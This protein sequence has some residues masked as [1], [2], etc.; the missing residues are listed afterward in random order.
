MEL[1]AIYMGLMYQNNLYSVSWSKRAGFYSNPRG[2]VTPTCMLTISP[3]HR[4]AAIRPPNELDYDFGFLPNTKDVR[5]SGISVD[6]SGGF[7]SN[8]KENYLSHNKNRKLS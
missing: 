1:M 5:K 3:S 7:Y 2:G 4:D 8:H 6:S